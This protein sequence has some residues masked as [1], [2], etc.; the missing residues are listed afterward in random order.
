M[1]RTVFL[2]C[3]FC[4]AGCNDAPLTNQEVVQIYAENEEEIAAI[5]VELGDEATMRDAVEEWQ[6][7]KR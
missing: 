3:V 6:R 1:L 4:L 7:R 2:L 5:W